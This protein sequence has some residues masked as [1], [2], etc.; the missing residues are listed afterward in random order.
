MKKQILIACIVC[1]AGALSWAQETDSLLKNKY[2]QETILLEGNKDK[3]CKNKKWKK[4]GLFKPNI[5]EEFLVTSAESKEEIHKFRKKRNRGSSLLLGG[6]VV[7]C[8]AAVAAPF[9]AL[10]A[11]VVAFGAGMGTYFVGAF[12]LQKSRSHL[13]KAVWLH[14]RDVMT[15]R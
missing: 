2:E 8:A 3:Y 15:M 6:G 10:P 5:E 4:V 1:L 12:D 9:I 14:N 7:F 13:S 11:F